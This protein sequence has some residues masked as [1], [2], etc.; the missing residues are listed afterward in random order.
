MSPHDLRR[1]RQKTVAHFNSIGSSW[2]CPDLI[3]NLNWD[4]ARFAYAPFSLS[5]DSAASMDIPLGFCFVGTSS[6]QVMVTVYSPATAPFSFPDSSV[7]EPSCLTTPVGRMA[8]TSF[9]DTG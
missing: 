3:L 9:P 8:V 4:D 5:R 2:F 6:G 1:R 7:K